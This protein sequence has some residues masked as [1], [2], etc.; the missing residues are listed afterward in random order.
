VEV[1]PSG[2]CVCVFD[3]V[4]RPNLSCPWGFHAG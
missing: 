3:N 1:S 2:V 4:L